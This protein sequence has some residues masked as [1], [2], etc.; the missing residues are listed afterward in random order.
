MIIRCVNWRN[1]LVTLIIAPISEI[2]WFTTVAVNRKTGA[3]RQ[4]RCTPNGTVP[5]EAGTIEIRP[6]IQ[7]RVFREDAPR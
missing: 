7:R 4:S 5:I 2:A 1:I 3:S 6:A